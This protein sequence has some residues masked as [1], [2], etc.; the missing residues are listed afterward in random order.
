[1]H[2]HRHTMIAARSRPAVRQRSRAG[3]FAGVTAI[4]RRQRIC[5]RPDLAAH[6]PLWPADARPAVAALASD[7]TPRPRAVIILPI[8]ATF[9]PAPAVAAPPPAAKKPDRE[10]IIAVPQDQPTL[11]RVQGSIR[12]QQLDD[13]LTLEPTLESALRKV[14]EGAL[15]R[16]LIMDLSESTSPISELSAARSVGG[17]DLKILALGT[18]NAVRLFPDLLPAGASAAL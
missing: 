12:D 4:D 17:P 6:R 8:G 10:G 7:K 13:D 9:T 3:I 18:V 16:I 15:P 14:R 11:D 5:R 1:R 2:P